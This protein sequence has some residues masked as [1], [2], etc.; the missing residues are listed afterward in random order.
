MCP[1]LEQRIVLYEDVKRIDLMNLV[2]KEET[3]APEAVYFSFPFAVGP[4]LP[5]G[6]TAKPVG[7]P[8]RKSG[9][10]PSQAV[11]AAGGPA[12]RFEIS[13]ADMAP[14]TEQLP[15]TTRDWHTVQHWV[16][17]AGRDA[18]VVWS[19]V[20]APLV[21]FG[22]I[23]TGKWLTKLDIMNAR[24]F[25]YAMNN[26]WMTNFKASQEGR[27]PFRY[28]LTSGPPVPAAEGTGGSDRVA[29]SR[30]GWEVHTPLAAAWI[31]AKNKGR[32]A[33]PAQS[34]IT[35]DA[36]NVIIQAF[37]LEGGLMPLV[38]LREI[39]GKAV[40]VHVATPALLM[41]GRSAA[42][43]RAGGGA[44]VSGGIAPSA[45]QV[46]VS[47]KPFEIRTVKLMKPAS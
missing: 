29:A 5:S 18:R 33:A 26:Y 17:F 30:F 22:D 12:V 6:E 9:A 41:Q 7:K 3:F 4:G 45:G 34:L 35:V 32:L 43:N 28:A 31:P 23:N 1:S 8:G 37:M 2:D 16:E 25:S 39:G 19:P 36:P 44:L 42:P 20:E 13:D 27:I 24:V 11:G 10:Q 38:R 14:E 15:G 21:E 40:E 46:V 47:L